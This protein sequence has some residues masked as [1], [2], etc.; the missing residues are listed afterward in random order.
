MTEYKLT[1]TIRNN[2]NSTCVFTPSQPGRLYQG[3]M[4]IQTTYTLNVHARRQRQ[5]GEEGW[6]WGGNTYSYR[7][8]ISRAN[9]YLHV[10]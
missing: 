9:N 6:W 1:P 4:G 5:G 7:L 3:K 2:R 8:S 10:Q